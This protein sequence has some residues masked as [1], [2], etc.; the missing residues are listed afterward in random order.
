MHLVSERALSEPEQV[1]LDS[2][3]DLRCPLQDIVSKLAAVT[4][5]LEI[6]KF[7]KGHERTFCCLSD[8]CS[9]FELKKIYFSKL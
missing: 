3:Q 4:F 7:Q 9:G 8:H 6:G 2:G 5:S 1:L